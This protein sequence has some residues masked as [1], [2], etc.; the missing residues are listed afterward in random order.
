VVFKGLVMRMI[1]IILTVIIVINAFLLSGQQKI[2]I[3]GT[4]YDS[5]TLIPA[6][7]VNV[8]ISGRNIGTVSCNSGLFELE[9]PGGLVNDSLTFS[10]IGYFDLKKSIK[11]LSKEKPN[12]I[13]IAPKTYQLDQVTIISE[14]LKEHTKGNKSRSGKIVLGLSKSL[15]LGREI[16]TKI[17]LPEKDVFLKKF[18]FHIVY[19][20]PDSARFRLNIYSYDNKINTN[21]LTKNIYFL[22]KGNY[23]GDYSLDLSKYNIVVKGDIFVSLETVAVYISKGP[24]KEKKN[25]QYFYDRINISGTVAGGTCYKREVS[26]GAWEK[27]KSFSPGFWLTVL[28]Y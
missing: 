13:Y 7:Y 16:G 2:Y 11:V 9:I 6:E 3:K 10:K 15:S 26:Q 28:Y 1:R 12:K 18:T 25:D 20:R 21:I 14:H 4:I 19:N 27:V 23:T 17:K 5:S 22:I 24:D 8:G